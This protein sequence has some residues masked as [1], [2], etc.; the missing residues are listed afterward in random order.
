MRVNSNGLSQSTIAQSNLAKLSTGYKL[1]Q[2]QNGSSVQS[3]S[4]KQLS[5]Q[6]KLHINS[7]KEDNA[8]IQNAITTTQVGES[9][10]SDINSCLQRMGYSLFLYIEP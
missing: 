3:T 6:I 2:S 1:N 10:L 7:I 4:S 9:A 5:D 8:E